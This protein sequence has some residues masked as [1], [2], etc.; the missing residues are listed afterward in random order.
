MRLNAECFTGE[1]PVEETTQLDEV[2]SH[3]PF[4]GLRRLSVIAQWPGARHRREYLGEPW[5][6]Q[7]RGCLPQCHKR[8]ILRAPVY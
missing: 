2:L 4:L 5:V 8:G 7:V 3:T 6:L 1:E